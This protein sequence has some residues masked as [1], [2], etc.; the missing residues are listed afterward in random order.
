MKVPIRSCPIFTTTSVST[1]TMRSQKS[2]NGTGR[3]TRSRR[4]GGMRGSGTG[5]NC[6]EYCFRRRH[7]IIDVRGEIQGRLVEHHLN[8]ALMIRSV[9]ASQSS[10]VLNLPKLN[11]TQLRA[12]DAVRPKAMRTWEGS[13]IPDV[14]AE[15]VDAANIG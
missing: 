14:Q 13:G 4:R 2:W 11:L 7:F 10:K 15:P 12:S 3:S 9:A 6:L 8:K 1:P 5:C